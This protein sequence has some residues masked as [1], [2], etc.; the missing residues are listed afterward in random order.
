M[1]NDDD[2]TWLTTTQAVTL[3]PAVTPRTLQRWAQKGSVQV[4]VL[5]SGRYRFRRSDVEKLARERQS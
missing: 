3:L 1:A 4:Q 2:S 5:A